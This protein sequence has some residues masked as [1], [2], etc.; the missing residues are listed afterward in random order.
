M[1]VA[2]GLYVRCWSYEIFLIMH[3]LLA[4]LIII[5]SWYHVN[6]RFQRQW[7]YEMWLYA[8]C[9][10]WVF[11]RLARVLRILKTGMRRAKVTD[12]GDG[13]VRIDVEGVRW[14]PAPGQHVYVFFPTLNPLRPWEN[15]PFSLMPTTLLRSPTTA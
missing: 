8:A 5:S 7:G 15:H 3:I 12:I 9:A 13:I 11:D 4:I 14:V 2:S 10:V 6:I 1:L